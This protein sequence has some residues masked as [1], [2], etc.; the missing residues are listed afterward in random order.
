M[1]KIYLLGGLALALGLSACSESKSTYTQTYGTTTLNIITDLNDGSTVASKGDYEFNLFI[2]MGN[3]T[4]TGTVSTT[5][6]ILNNSSV[7]FTTVDQTYSTNLY[8]AYF[9]NVKAQNQNLTDATFLLTPFFYIPSMFNVD[10]SFTTP[11]NIILAQYTIND[12]YR[13]RTFQEKTFFKGTTQTHYQ[14]GPEPE[15]FTTEDIYYMLTIDIEKNTASIS[16]FNAKFSSSE[17]EPLKKQIDVDG[18]TVEYGDG[19]IT[20]KGE[21]IVPNLVE[22][23]ESTPYPGFIFNNIEFKTTGEDLTGC[24]IN[25]LVAGMFNGSF[26]GI[27]AE[28]EYLN[29]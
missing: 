7:A 9:T 19:V 2:D 13:V 29:Q 4:H 5:N 12:A 25:F 14:M 22:A 26:S 21:D 3:D 24:E 23:G 15:N 16:M 1:K 11:R 10:A 8:D 20:V 18:L 28:T 27:Y 17:K 6:L